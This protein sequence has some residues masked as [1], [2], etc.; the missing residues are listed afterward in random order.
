MESVCYQTYTDFECILVDDGSTDGS[1]ELCDQWA[2]KDYRFRSIHKKNEGVSAARN[3][4]LTVAK[5]E[6][7]MFVDSDDW[8]ANDKVLKDLNKYIEDEDVITLDYQ[9]YM[10]GRETGAGK[11]IEKTAD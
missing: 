2:K 10:A 6:L 7:V 5:G 3:D 4:G 8:L 1:R 9:Y 11:W